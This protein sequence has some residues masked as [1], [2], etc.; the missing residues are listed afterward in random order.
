MSNLRSQVIKLAHAKPELRAD[1]LPLLKEG[2]FKDRNWPRWMRAKYPGMDE[3]GKP[4]PAGTQVLYWPET[5]TFQTGKD[6]DKSWH[7]FESDYVEYL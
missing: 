1:L 7:D 5:K 2:G 3:K 4:F 6:A